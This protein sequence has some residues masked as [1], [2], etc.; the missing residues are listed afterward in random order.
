MQSCWKQQD[1]IN[2]YEQVTRAADL[3]TSLLVAARCSDTDG[4]EQMLSLG[5]NVNGKDDKGNTPLHIAAAAGHLEVRCTQ[6]TEQYYSSKSFSDQRLYSEPRKDEFVDETCN[7]GSETDLP[8]YEPCSG[9]ERLVRCLLQRGASVKECNGEGKSA[10]HIA[11]EYGQVNILKIL[12]N[13]HAEINACDADGHTPMHILAI[14]GDIA[15]LQVFLNQNKEHGASVTNQQAEAECKRN[16]LG[17]RDNSVE[18]LMLEAAHHGQMRTVKFLVEQ[19]ADINAKDS[20]GQTPLMLLIIHLY[21]EKCAK[22]KLVRQK[23]LLK[24]MFCDLIL[25]LLVIDSTQ[26]STN[27]VDI[28]ARNCSGETALMIALQL[29]LMFIAERLIQ[30]GAHIIVY[31]IRG[32][33]ALHYAMEH[34]KKSDFKKDKCNILEGILNG[35]AGVNTTSFDGGTPLHLATKRGSTVVINWLIAN[36]AALRERNRTGKEMID[37][38][39]HNKMWPFVN[40][41]LDADKSSRPKIKTMLAHCILDNVSC[42]NC[43][44][45]VL[46]RL[47][48]C[49]LADSEQ[50]RKL[51]STN[52]VEN[53]HRKIT[54]VDAM[55]NTTHFCRL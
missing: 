35:G 25:D 11:A 55:E 9:Y 2:E 24:V 38:A 27:V 45:A 28:N 52:Y 23:K 54:A 29:D 40:N 48:A 47:P 19:G 50:R 53:V 20:Q 5:S 3:N 51:F 34:I 31:D 42:V 46:Q 44:D 43:L 41:M 49:K 13:N 26:R 10:L 15:A 36:G 30:L 16:L 4:V 14:R 32:K 8:L 12:L 39:I 1:S 6:V 37:F 22:R 18:T 17:M 7:K 21:K 33:S